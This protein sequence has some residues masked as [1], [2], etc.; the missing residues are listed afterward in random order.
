MERSKPRGGGA[1]WEPC[2][3]PNN[4]SRG[5]R[6]PLTPRSPS[7]QVAPFQW[8]VSAEPL[9]PDSEDEQQNRKGP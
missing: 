9:V 6:H 4:L 5:G 2:W 7:S 1:G 3:V 8:P